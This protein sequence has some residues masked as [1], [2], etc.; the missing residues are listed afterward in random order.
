LKLLL[1]RTLEE[2]A[3]VLAAFGKSMRGKTLVTFNGQSF[4]W[5][6]V[7][8]RARRLGVALPRPHGHFDLLLSARRRWRS[9]LPN[10]RLQTLERGICGRG[11]EGDIPSSEIPGRYYHFLRES[12]QRGGGG[13]LLAPVLFHNALDVMTMAELICHLAEGA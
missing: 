10:C 12:E 9:R 5:P 6:F 7:Q 8:G 11:R 13:H 3:A 2:E 1:A 4:D